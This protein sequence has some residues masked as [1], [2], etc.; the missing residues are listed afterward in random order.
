[1]AKSPAFYKRY[2][3]AVFHRGRATNLPLSY[4]EQEARRVLDA[5]ELELFHAEIE[6]MIQEG[7][8][9]RQGEMLRLK[10]REL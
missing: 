2:V 8:L 4:I 5:R 3:T 6:A 10:P 9:L 1:M 7:E